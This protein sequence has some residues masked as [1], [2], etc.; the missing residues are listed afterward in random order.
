MEIEKEDGES[1]REN[2]IEK[3]DGEREHETEKEDGK[4]EREWRMGKR[5]ERARERMK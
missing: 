1:K 4:R 5:M 2:E 3:E